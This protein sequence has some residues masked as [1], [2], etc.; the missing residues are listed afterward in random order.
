VARKPVATN[1]IWVN[2]F[3]WVEFGNFMSDYIE[4]EP[5]FL[6]KIMFFLWFFAGDLWRVKS[7]IYTDPVPK[8]S[9]ELN[10]KNN[11]RKEARDI[12]NVAVDNCL[13]G[14]SMYYYTCEQGTLVWPNYYLLSIVSVIFDFHMFPLSKYAK[15]NWFYHLYQKLWQFEKRT[16]F[17][18]HPPQWHC[19]NTILWFVTSTWSSWQPIICH[20]TVSCAGCTIILVY[21]V[22]KLECHSY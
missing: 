17:L 7:E 10:L 11:I 19:D 5:S 12:V 3:Y 14:A 9:E 22:T 4:A 8:T 15:M 18:K 2:A 21:K 6:I 20:I 1:I 13:K 16:F